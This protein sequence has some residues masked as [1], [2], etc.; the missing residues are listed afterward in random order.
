MVDWCFLL[1]VRL[2]G[3]FCC[4]F[5]IVVLFFD[6]A[7]LRNQWFSCQNWHGP[8]DPLGT[9]WERGVGEEEFGEYY[10]SEMGGEGCNNQPDKGW[11]Q[12]S[13]NKNSKN[14]QRI[15]WCSCNKSFHGN[16]MG[17]E[18]GKGFSKYCLLKKGWEGCNDQPEEGRGWQDSTTEIIILQKRTTNMIAPVFARALPCENMR[19]YKYLLIPQNL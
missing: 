9:W 5:L 12:D 1:V 2:R 3:F 10:W 19:E 8:K 13:K 14:S 18:W 4:W 6:I 16:F 15:T 17:E 7:A 11:W